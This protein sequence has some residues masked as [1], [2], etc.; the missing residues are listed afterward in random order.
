MTL[1]RQFFQDYRDPFNPSFQMQTELEKMKDDNPK[2]EE[3]I[4]QLEEELAVQKIKFKVK[5]VYNSFEL[6]TKTVSLN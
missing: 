3:K 5:T 6:D 1:I 2:L 4:I